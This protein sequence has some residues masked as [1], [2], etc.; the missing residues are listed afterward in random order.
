MKRVVLY[1]NSS[2]LNE[3]TRHYIGIINKAASDLGYIFYITESISNIKFSDIILTIV[4]NNFFKA[5]LLRPFSKTLFWS[6]GIE[7]EECW[8]REN[9]FLKYYAKNIIEYIAL[10]F[11]GMQ[12]LVSESM[13]NHYK[14]KYGIN[15]LNYQIMP[16]YNSHY[17]ETINL[18]MA[19]YDNPTFVY[20]GSLSAWQNIDE[21]LQVYKHIENIIP[22]ATLT[23]LTEENERAQSLIEQYNIQNVQV[24]YV[25][26]ND[27]NNELLKYKYGFLL[28]KDIKVN[29]VAT[30]TKMSSYL[31]SGVIPVYKD[32]IKDF[33]KHINLNNFNL[34]L[35]EQDSIEEMANA[36]IS[37]E[38]SQSDFADLDIHIKNIFDNYFNDN[39][40]IKQI[41][42][43]LQNHLS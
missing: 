14:N 4:P 42:I 35:T 19:R 10:R 24:R 33:S 41:K 11:S 5:L 36:I 22:E 40:Y 29:H 28:R 30:P 23:L 9:N 15:L 25:S 32:V 38:N 8:L 31:A 26:L 13:L 39:E 27:L 1:A 6:Q 16:C 37:F 7:P 17:K 34:R 2:S 20:A 12:F 43:K 21:T 3:A 18:N